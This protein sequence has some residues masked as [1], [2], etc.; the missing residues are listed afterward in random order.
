[1]ESPSPSPDACCQAL[2]DT[3]FEYFPA[4]KAICD[5]GG[6]HSEAGRFHFFQRLCRDVRNGQH[7]ETANELT[8][9]AIRDA[10]GKQERSHLEKAGVIGLVYC[11]LLLNT[12]FLSEL[13]VGSTKRIIDDKIN[14]TA[15]DPASLAY[16]V[17][18]TVV[19]LGVYKN[20]DVG[21]NVFRNWLENR[22]HREGE[23]KVKSAKLASLLLR[24]RV[25]E[26]SP[27][28]AP[29]ATA[30]SSAP[31][32]SSV[33][34]GD[35][36]IGLGANSALRSIAE[37]TDSSTGSLY[38]RI[39][40]LGVGPISA[41]RSTAK[42]TDSLYPGFSFST[43]GH[44][45]T[46]P[47]DIS[48]LT[49]GFPDYRAQRGRLTGVNQAM[50][51]L[52]MVAEE[53]RSGGGAG[54]GENNE[55]QDGGGEGG[56]MLRAE[57]TRGGGNGGN[58]E[59]SDPPR[60]PTVNVMFHRHAEGVDGRR[61]TG[62]GHAEEDGHGSHRRDALPP[63][64]IAEA[65]RMTLAE[66]CKKVRRESGMWLA[67]SA[68]E[69]KEVCLVVHRNGFGDSEEG[70][71]VPFDRLEEYTLGGLRQDGLVTFGAGT[72]V[73]IEVKYVKKANLE[74]CGEFIM[75]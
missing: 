55:N 33:P 35:A 20:D 34:A 44:D 38:T 6:P 75:P 7:N 63:I 50:S 17:I 52:E 64:V 4:V 25:E 56:G 32:N 53:E 9:T 30:A 27:L 42:S 8:K 73:C 37:S 59:I 14:S 62:G 74:E 66:L 45:A 26:W 13:A 51:A 61:G 57:D 69:G 49:E 5:A 72:K 3:L 16:R 65:T 22:K 21:L 1:M 12:D 48:A 43:H 68:A 10:V 24:C 31:A 18:A 39:E 60:V 47:D 29:A 23:K 11:L 40:D 2:L 70:Y 58:L 71:E 28:P 67:P 54:G 41:P 15:S 46:I 36:L 19:E